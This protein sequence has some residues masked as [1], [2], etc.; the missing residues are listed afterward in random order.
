M[1]LGHNFQVVALQSSTNYSNKLSRKYFPRCPFDDF[2]TFTLFISFLVD[3]VNNRENINE[4]LKSIFV[5]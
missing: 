4:K 5:I 2:A 1:P 3:K